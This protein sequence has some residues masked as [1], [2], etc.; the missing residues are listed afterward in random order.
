MTVEEFLKARYEFKVGD[1]YLT[2]DGRVEDV[3]NDEFAEVMNAECTDGLDKNRY[4]L[5]AAALE[6]PKRTKAEYV[7]VTDSIFDLK[8][9]F[10]DGW[11]SSKA[12]G[13]YVNIDNLDSLLLAYRNDNVYRKVETEIDERQE[14]I[15]ELSKIQKEIGDCQL[16]EFYEAIFD[17]GKFKLVN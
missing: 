1:L 12:G 7:K 14:F 15:D 16:G 3:H 8:S 2:S 13:H 9:E 10:E 11:L 5:R 17:S 6:K 4:I